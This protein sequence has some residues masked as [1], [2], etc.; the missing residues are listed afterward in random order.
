MIHLP[1]SR[2]RCLSVVTI[3]ASL[4]ALWSCGGVDR[5]DGWT[6]ATHGKDTSPNYDLLFTTSEVHSIDI[7]I[8]AS[9]YQAMQDDL[10]SLFSGSGGLP[11]GD[12]PDGGMPGGGEPPAEMIAACVG[13]AEND[14]CEVTVPQTMQGTCQL[15]IGT[16]VCMPEGGTPDGGEIPVGGDVNMVTLGDPIY[17]PAEVHHDGR[18]WWYVGMRYKGNSSLSATYR[19]GNGKLPFR[20]NFDRYESE[21]PKID[22]QRFYGFKD[23]T[24]ASNWSDD[25]QIREAFA[26]ELF[27]ERGVPAARCAFYRVSVDVGNGLEYWGLYT[28]IEDPSDKGMLDSQLGSHNGNLYKPEGT[29]ADWTVFDQA[30]FVKKNNEDAADWSDVEAAISALLADQSDAAAWRAGLEP[31]FDVDAFLRWLA[32]NTAMQNWDSY[33]AMAHNYYLYGDPTNGGRLRWIPWDHNL[34]MMAQGDVMGG[35]DGLDPGG[36]TEVDAYTEILHTAAGPNW[37]LI[38]RALADPTYR[39]RYR[40]LLSEVL[41]GLFE[42]ENAAARMREMHSLIEPH[43]IGDNGENATHTT[44]SSAEAFTQSVD[45]EE[46]L[47]AHIANRHARVAEALAA[48]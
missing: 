1:Q 38:S 44:I 7:V 23:L 9:D 2:Y 14:A 17:V 25:S 24:F 3:L 26:S 45:G 16:L 19:A 40:D 43:V 30:G 22:D 5:P 37:P 15:L 32:V 35:A 20:L 10:A 48:Q 21:H 34:S 47:V 41:G 27:R 29:G 4:P 33:G 18:T 36:G 39:Q 46:G 13:L 28:A 8:K 11:G 6:E 42:V 12:I 31:A